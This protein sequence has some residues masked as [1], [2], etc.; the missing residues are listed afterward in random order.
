MSS[1]AAIDALLSKAARAGEVPG[2]VALAANAKGLL[3]EGAFGSLRLPDGAPM[4][5]DS[6]FWI[7]SLTKAL[8]AVAAMQLVEEGQLGLDQPIGAFIPQLAVPQVLDGFASDGSPRLRPARS[9]V[10]LRNLLT[11]TS[12]FAYENWNAD[13]RRYLEATGLPAAGT[14]RLAALGVPLMFEPGERW[15]Y[16]IGID[17]VGRVI[18]AASG[19]RLDAYFAE[20]IFAPLGMKDSAYGLRPEQTARMAQVHV[21]GSDGRLAAIVREPPAVT[22][23]YPGGGSL[24]S[25]A[26]D[27]MTFLRMLLGHGQ[28]GPARILRPETVALMS[29]NQIGELQAGRLISVA[30]TMSNDF[31]PPRGIRHGWGLSF[32]INRDDLPGRRSAGSLAWAGMGNCYYW[33]DSKHAIAGLLLTQILPFADRIVLD[34][35]EAFERE[36]YAG[37]A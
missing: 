20:R 11:H 2:V 10:T 6:I 3:Y 17:W 8:T 15:E 27:Y 5:L 22:E 34:L 23:F 37:L 13:M 18:E 31:L 33:L 4:R 12:G 32:L 21:R 30:P 16:G 9:A 29:Q 26:R 14:R 25:T 19:K 35:F 1:L 28:L 24:Y 36:V 7:A